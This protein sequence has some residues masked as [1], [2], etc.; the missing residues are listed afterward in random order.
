VPTDF[1]LVR[2]GGTIAHPGLVLQIIIKD[3]FTRLKFHPLAIAIL[4]LKR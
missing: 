4:A 2:F 3:I 1:G